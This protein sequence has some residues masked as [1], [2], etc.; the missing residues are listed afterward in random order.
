[1]LAAALQG[2]A[3][4]SSAF[5]AFAS[6]E[7]ALHGRL[8][9]DIIDADEW[10]AAEG[11]TDDVGGGPGADAIEFKQL[12]ISLLRRQASNGFQVKLA[13]ADGC[14]GFDNQVDSFVGDL[15]RL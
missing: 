6:V 9:G 1:M 2:L 3:D 11:A 10:I 13:T 7:V 8:Q 4:L 15:Q 14:G 5:V 12:F